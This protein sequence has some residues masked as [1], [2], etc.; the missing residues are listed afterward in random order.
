[1]HYFLDTSSFNL[2]LINHTSNNVIDQ[3]VE[4]CDDGLYYDQNGTGLCRPECGEYRYNPVNE[5]RAFIIISIVASVTM[6]IM[7]FTF[8]RSTL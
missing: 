1:M 6:F 8:Q 3:Q 4:E 2:E 5:E 7:T